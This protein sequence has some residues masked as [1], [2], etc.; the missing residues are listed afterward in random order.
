MKNKENLILC[1][2]KQMAQMLRLP[3]NVFKP[4]FIKIL[5]KW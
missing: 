5:Q 1:E 2:K 3:N 4:A